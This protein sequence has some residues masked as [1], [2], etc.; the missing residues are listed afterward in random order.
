MAVEAGPVEAAKLLGR[1]H[2]DVT[3]HGDG[4]FVLAEPWIPSWRASID[5]RDVP[6]L[7]VDYALTGLAIAAGR[8]EVRFERVDRALRAA[9]VLSLLALVVT[10]ALCIPTRR[11]AP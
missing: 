10:L 6:V 9:A 3:V 4:L 8:H 2:F 7:R 1:E 5:G 11:R